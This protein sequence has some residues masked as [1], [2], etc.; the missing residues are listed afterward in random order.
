MGRNHWMSML[1]E[2]CQHLAEKLG[3]I[4]KLDYVTCY[5]PGLCSDRGRDA[6]PEGFPVFCICLRVCVCHLTAWQLCPNLVRQIHAFYQFQ[7]L[8][9]LTGSIV[10]S[11]KTKKM[12]ERVKCA[13]AW[14]SW[15]LAS[16]L[17][18]EVLTSYGKMILTLMT[19][20]QWNYVRFSMDATGKTRKP[21]IWYLN[22][23]ALV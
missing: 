16:H 22:E 1:A 4:G 9:N 8:I 20:I 15:S 3:N 23:E 12:C 18:S 7:I 14:L 17:N 11:Q 21:Q 6:L 10:S 19:Y 2:F 13:G 5:R